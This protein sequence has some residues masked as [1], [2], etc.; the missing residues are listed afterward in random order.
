MGSKR[1]RKSFRKIHL[2]YNWLVS[3]NLSKSIT[4]TRNFFRKV[5]FFKMTCDYRLI[6]KIA[7]QSQIVPKMFPVLRSYKPNIW[8]YRFII[9]IKKLYQTSLPPIERWK[10]LKIGLEFC[11]VKN[12]S[13]NELEKWGKQK[14]SL[15]CVYLNF[16]MWI[17]IRS[18]K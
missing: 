17:A 1:K 16:L 10:I 3:K 18:R 14:L 12:K 8:N 5:L 7:G 6:T 15:W 13:S 4:N 11:S 9:F 2:F